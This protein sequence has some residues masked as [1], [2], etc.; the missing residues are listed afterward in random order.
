MQGQWNSDLNEIGKKQAKVNGNFLS[1]QS[2]DALLVSP[3]D[4]TRQTADIINQYLGLQITYDD[5]IMEWDCGDWSGY[6][7]AEVK[8]KW[9]KEWI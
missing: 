9:A 5:R 4:R 7:Y 1:S 2:I 8:V 6:L 3:L